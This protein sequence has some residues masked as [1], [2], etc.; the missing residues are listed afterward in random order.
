MIINNIGYDH[1]HDA[2][3]Y[4]DR[5]DGSGDFLL[6][7]LK[8]G[9]VFTIDNKD[10]T[11]PENTFFLYPKGTPQY[12]RCISKNIFTNDWI[13]FD[14]ENNEEENLKKLDIPYCK[15]IKLNNIGY[16]SFC[17]KLIAYE[18]CSDNIHKSNTINHYMSIIFNKVSEQIK[19]PINS[20]AKTNHETLVT[21][22]NKIY[23]RPYEFRT[24]ES[25]AH[26]VNMSKS[27]FQHE[28]KKTFNTTFVMDLIE[29]R[30][31]YAKVLLENTDLT[32]LEISKQCGYGTYTHF[33][34]Q[35]KEKCGITP[36][37]YRM[38]LKK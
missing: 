11:V 1:S 26:E 4:I 5:P 30:I 37:N 29:S 38:N 22:R 19:K 8:T 15:P 7:L 21:I 34:R 14:F 32:A 12:Y 18:S 31:N 33:T 28:Y 35:F 13:H 2:D 10:I 16:L 9:A 17:I 36:L 20:V 23:S 27:L 6:L 3:F 24:V 25:T